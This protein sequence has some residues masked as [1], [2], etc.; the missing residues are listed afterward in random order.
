M[1]RMLDWSAKFPSMRVRIFFHIRWLLIAMSLTAAE[2]G[3]RAYRGEI[4]KWRK[5]Y[6]A[7]LRQDNGWLTLA[8]L[9][10]LK[11][12]NNR[13][14]AGLGNDI[15]LPEGSA[16]E[17]A[18][19]FIFHHGNTRLLA[20][21]GVPVLLNGKPVLAEMPLKPDTTGQPDRIALGR[22]SM[23]VIQRGSRHGIR[24]WDN[25]NRARRDFRGTHWFPVTE[26]HRLTAR[27]VSYPQ[28]KMIPI[29]NVLGDI[30]PNPSPGY[31]EFEIDGKPCRLEPVLEGNE[32]FFLLKD[33]TSG[34]QTYPAGRFLYT[35]LPKDG[36]VILDFNKAHNPPCAFTAFATCPLPPRQNYLPVPI[37]AGELNYE[38]PSDTAAPA[39]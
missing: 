11:E 19:T 37:D 24:L 5:N 8:G 27:F 30:D 23:I 1:E 16:P 3:D 2:H 28:P 22:L 31:A 29:V 9:F 14:G 17:K 15:V 20:Q 35:D 38:H 39:K 6:E 33:L 34:K 7:N 26:S 32:L 13:F 10:W 21:H 36:K 4:Q 25:A 18:G 12:G